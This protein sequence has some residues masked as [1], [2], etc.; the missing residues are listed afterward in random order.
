MLASAAS[1]SLATWLAHEVKG[2]RARKIDVAPLIEVAA[3]T[4][5]T[6]GDIR[7]AG[8]RSDVTAAVRYALP[9]PWDKPGGRQPSDAEIDAWE[10]KVK[11]HRTGGDFRLCGVISERTI[12]HI[13]EA[14]GE[15]A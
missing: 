7:I 10:A 4:P 8:V 12:L 1:G 6:V 9:D 14:L 5:G 15:K 2:T 13:A 3:N 11:Q